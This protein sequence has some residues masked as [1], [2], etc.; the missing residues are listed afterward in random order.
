MP[1]AQTR[2]SR[3]R[4]EAARSSPALALR[5][6]HS[7]FSWAHG[8]QR[9]GVCPFS[10][11]SRAATLHQRFAGLQRTIGNQAV[12][13]LL[14]RSAP[15]I[16][17]KLAINQPGDQYEQEADRVAEQ[18]MRMPDPV[19]APTLH[20]SAGNGVSLQRK[21]VECEEEEK[22]Q[23]KE[24]G[25]GPEF[26]P[27]IVQEVLDSPGQP[28]D[29]GARDFFEP[30]F[31]HDFG[32]VRIHTG[33]RAAQSANAVH[34]RAYT[35]GH[36]VVLGSGEFQDNSPLGRTILAHELAHVLQQNDRHT[37][38][39][40]FLVQRSGDDAPMS[41]R[42]LQLACVVR[43]GGCASSR[44]GG[45][46]T[47][48]EIQDYN[49]RCAADYHYSGPDIHPTNEECR[50]PP[51]EPLSTGEKILLGLFLLAGAAVVGAAVIVAGEVVI[52]VVIASVSE[53]AEAGL[54]Y[55]LTNAIVVNEIGV[56]AAGVLLSCEGDV[57]GLL[58]A[59]AEDPAQGALLL[60]EIYMLHVDISIANGPARRAAVPVKL[61]PPEEQTGVESR[62][63]KF[64]SV[65]PPT[66]EEQPAEAPP[67]SAEVSPGATSRVRAPAPVEQ[68]I[69][70]IERDIAAER[71]AVAQKK[72]GTPPAKW[73]T[74]RAGATKRLYNLLERRAVLARV[75]AFPGR[76]YLEQA[77]I[78]GVES[79]GQLTPTSSIS[80]SGTGRIADILEVNG[81][82]I[83]LED[84]K[85]PSTQVGSIKG[86]LQSPDVEAE[87][88]PS[89]E[90]EKQHT[91]EQEV[92]A[93]AKRVGGKIIIVGRDPVSGAPATLAVDPNSLK[94]RVTDYTA[95]GNN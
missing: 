19:A 64:R 35:V 78:T 33:A 65:G 12:L 72:S 83:I 28:L 2:E 75:K 20:A 90:I 79:G 88:R 40:G 59:I 32:H 51:R 16:Q 15:A 91:V 61:L 44:D 43:L 30:R 3:G 92:I 46:P 74:A 47:T 23:R 9:T 67:P 56:F 73:R 53:L 81:T 14:S 6:E 95:F 13:R 76:T 48:E 21:C 70:D 24:I 84:L 60:A 52:P 45:I 27:P 62:Q 25:S 80:T 4:S 58:R 85:S 39:Q 26:A 49:K 8:L 82:D 34:A 5:Q 68:A 18:V 42:D 31:G 89:S 57:G 1:K 63:I 29:K 36:N 17:R 38:P 94:S 87:F 37:G 66:F 50:N 11:V 41:P 77:K 10:V 93:E 22:L 7:R 69:T 71:S 55:Y 54:A 86:G